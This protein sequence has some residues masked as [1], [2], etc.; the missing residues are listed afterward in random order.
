MNKNTQVSFRKS[1]FI[2][3]C[4][5]FNGPSQSNIKLKRQAFTVKSIK[6]IML[7][8]LF[9]CSPSCP[10][11]SSSSS[12]IL[13]TVSEV[14]PLLP[15]FF[16][17]RTWAGH[18]EQTHSRPCVKAYVCCTDLCTEGFWFSL[19]FHERQMMLTLR[20]KQRAE[21]VCILIMLHLLQ[22]VTDAW[23]LLELFRD[24]FLHQSA[25]HHAAPYLSVPH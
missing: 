1:F 13:T 16:S 14:S 15:L 24:F 22:H 20:G 19:L 11:R 25:D 3:S 8:S 12:S 18:Y 21:L 10:P 17:I 5:I 4:C 6:Q 23:K 2:C 7:T 9:H